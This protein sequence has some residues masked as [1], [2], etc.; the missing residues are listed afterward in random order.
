[1]AFELMEEAYLNFERELNADPD[2]DDLNE[3][4]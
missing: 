3:L 1:V 2:H 4:R